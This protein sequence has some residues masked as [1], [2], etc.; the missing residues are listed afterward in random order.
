MKA[1]KVAW[2]EFSLLTNSEKQRGYTP[3]KQ[4]TDFRRSQLDSKVCVD[5]TCKPK[6]GSAVIT[7]KGAEM[8]SK[9]NLIRMVDNL[10]LN[11]RPKNSPETK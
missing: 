4:V 2:I 11:L 5:D 10:P 1:G 8:S 9:K 7:T 3:E 6:S